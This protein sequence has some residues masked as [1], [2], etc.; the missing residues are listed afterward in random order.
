MPLTVV[1]C[2]RFHNTQID[3]WAGWGIP[4][5]ILISYEI[6]WLAEYFRKS[7]VYF[8]LLMSTI[9]FDNGLSNEG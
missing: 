3:S 5:E 2:A 6:F 4:I 9:E 7:V 8:L 1:S